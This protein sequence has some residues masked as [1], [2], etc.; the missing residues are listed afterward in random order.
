MTMA[1]ESPTA[2]LASL[3]S[4]EFPPRRI[5][6]NLF[7]AQDAPLGAAQIQTRDVF[8]AKWA[9]TAHGGDA[10]NR[11]FSKQMRWYFELYGFRDESDLTRYLSCC[12]TIVDCGTGTGFKAAWFAKLAPHATVIGVDISDSVY[13]SA[14]YYRATVPNL[15]FLKGDIGNMPYFKEAVFDFVNCDQVIHHTSDPVVTF[16]E[17]VRI[18]RPSR[19]LACYVYR[20]KALPR[21]LLDEYFRQA[22]KAMS[23]KDLM[24]L[25]NQLTDLGHLLSTLDDHLLDIPDIPALQIKGGQMTIQRFIYWNFLKCYWDAEVGRDGSVMTN[26]D[27]YSPSQA[28]RFSE[29]EFRGWIRASNLEEIF[30]H[31][32]PACYSGRFRRSNRK[33]A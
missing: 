32:E 20:R 16:R 25:S 12:Q 17:L 30:F 24:N 23:H 19:D 15:L 26:F 31:S 7:V 21:E 2:R 1:A 3:L 10:F 9:E 28:Q 29:D 13:A 18:T 14:E 27:W 22:C 5:A 4:D 11:I 33:I 8:A 6:D